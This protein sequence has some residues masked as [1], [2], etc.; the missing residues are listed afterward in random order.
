[1]GGQSVESL[2]QWTADM[3][4]HEIKTK[5]DTLTTNRFAD[6]ARAQLGR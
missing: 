1:M 5:W 6:L 2:L 4:G 3:E